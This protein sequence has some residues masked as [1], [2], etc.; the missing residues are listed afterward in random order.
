MDHRGYNMSCAA[1]G[2]STNASGDRL[3]S[4]SASKSGVTVVGDANNAANTK[5][6]GLANGGPSNS[7][8][9]PSSRSTRNTDA[10]M[11]KW[12]AQSLRNVM[13]IHREIAAASLRSVSK[14]SVRKKST[15]QEGKA[16]KISEAVAAGK[17][18]TPVSPCSLSSYSTHRASLCQKAIDSLTVSLLAAGVDQIQSFSA[19]TMES[20][21]GVAGVTQKP[22]SRSRSRQRPKPDKPGGRTQRKGESAGRQPIASLAAGE[23]EGA[24]GRAIDGTRGRRKGLWHVIAGT[25]AF[26]I[27]TLENMAEIYAMRC[28]ARERLGLLEAAFDDAREASR[29]TARVGG[30]GIPI[31]S[32][33]EQKHISNIRAPPMSW[34][35]ASRCFSACD[36]R[37]VRG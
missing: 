36:C 26:A 35:F 18:V 16:A 20:S 23:S 24:A 32:V 11:L 21:A 3:K 8:Q 2:K 29:S 12:D 14:T 19:E 13:D 28:S 15:A 4:T 9:K 31:E 17:H 10:L 6:A 7:K 33:R 25:P 1:G 22:D 37:C 30:A 27:A 5:A 34:R